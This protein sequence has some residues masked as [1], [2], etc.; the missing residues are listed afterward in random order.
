MSH[1]PVPVIDPESAEEEHL[2]ARI[3]ALRGEIAAA[4]G[5]LE[6][7]RATLTAF[8][9][10]Y[11]ARIGVLIVELD[12]VELEIATWRRRNDALRESPE[13]L[14]AVEEQI[15][16]EFHSE[17]ERVDE[18][19][20]EASE[21]GRRAAT[22]PPEPSPEI[23]SVIR[24]RYRRLARRFHPDVA[25]DEV[26]RGYNEQAMKRINAAMETND[27]AA[28][29]HLELVLPARE[30]D[31]PGPTRRARI[32]WATSEIARLES[33]LT[34]LVGE[35]AGLRASSVHTFWDR[36]QRDSSLL[37]RLERDL[38]SEIATRRME[39]HAL[40][41]DHQT[42]LREHVRLNAGEPARV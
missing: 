21:S 25:T 40:A 20:R 30:P 19:L 14:K 3:E 17:Q 9:A 36:V 16:R 37:D 4:A 23:V 38:T 6:E 32:A 10:R 33:A 41:Q 15:E 42:L 12:R 29:D 7:H 35:L 2:R 8:E 1:V 11:D 22:L 31:I 18:E 26:E 39:L 13:I 28:L 27:L 24:E 5:E 34:R